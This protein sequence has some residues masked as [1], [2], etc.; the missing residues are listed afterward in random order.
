MGASDNEPDPTVIMVN[1]NPAQIAENATNITQPIH[2]TRVS[3]AGR[4]ALISRYQ[5]IGVGTCGMAIPAGTSRPV[6]LMLG[7]KLISLSGVYQWAVADWLIFGLGQQD[8][9]Y[10]SLKALCASPEWREIGGPAYQTCNNWMTVARAFPEPR[11][12][13]NLDYSHH[14]NLTRLPQNRQE[15]WLDWCEQTGA[16]VDKLAKA[17]EEQEPRPKPRSRASK[18]VVGKEVEHLED[19]L[20]QHYEA[21]ILQIEQLREDGIRKV[22]VERRQHLAREIDK[23]IAGLTAARH[24]IWSAEDERSYKPSSH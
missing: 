8:F 2:E 5:E 15:Y 3:M 21:D 6:W 22:P 20:K 17:V 1:F 24:D 10:K 7:R 9:G 13:D 18:K 12:R 19:Q 14:A 4:T 16:T 11:R 23:V